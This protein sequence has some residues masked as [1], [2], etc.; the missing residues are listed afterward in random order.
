MWLTR[1]T[2]NSTNEL[3]CDPFHSTLDEYSGISDILL[4]ERRNAAVLHEN[5]GAEGAGGAGHLVVRLSELKIWKQ[6]RQK[7][8]CWSRFRKTILH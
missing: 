5:D 8:D 3:A 1:N 7:Q 4:G 2:S 6:G